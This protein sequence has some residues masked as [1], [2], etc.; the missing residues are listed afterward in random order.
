M[1]NTEALQRFEAYLRR[2]F[3]HRRTPIDYV[4]DVR[5]FQLGCSQA[6]DTVTVQHIDQFVDQMHQKELKP[7]TVTRRVMA[8][9]VYFDFLAN[10][11]NDFDHPNPVHLKR[12]A[13]KLGQHLP[14]D[15]SDA[16]VA[17][18]WESIQSPRDR[19]LVALMWHAGLRVAEVVGLTREDVIVTPAVDPVPRLPARVRV[20]GK[21]QKERIV[22]LNRP[23]YT[24]LQA[25]LGVRP[26]VSC[27]T[28]FL[29]DRGQPL[30][31]N[32]VEW[33]LKGYGE[34]LG[35]HLT[36]HRLRHTFAR[37]LKRK[38]LSAYWPP[39]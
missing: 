33:L 37:Q 18:L 27:R 3:P 29:N 17:R 36:P 9:K 31:A 15:L 20:L 5:Q 38:L 21:G 6:W 12:H 22:Y 30:R 19:A 10:D 16:Q 35:I 32:G 2:R 26:A 13:A 25:W 8:L 34:K 4:C 11:T 23:A 14:H 7:A 28:L 39:Q 24:A 1:D